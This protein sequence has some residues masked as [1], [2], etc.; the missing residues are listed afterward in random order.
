MTTVDAHQPL[1]LALV[2]NE[3]MLGATL[4]LEIGAVPMRSVVQGGGRAWRLSAAQLRRELQAS[5]AFASVGAEQRL[6]EFSSRGCTTRTLVID[7]SRP[8]P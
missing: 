7:D 1:E 2:G 6:S 3:G 4:L 5:P 8:Q